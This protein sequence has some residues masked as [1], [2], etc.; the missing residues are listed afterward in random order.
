MSEL[1]LKVLVTGGN[2][3]L[4][5]ELRVLSKSYPYVWFFTDREV[6]DITNS[7]A[8]TSFLEKHQ[9]DVIINAAAYTAVDR[10]ETEVDMATAINHGAVKTLA[11]EAAKRGIKLVNISTDYVFDGEGK[12]PYHTDALC[13]PKSMYGITKRHGEMAMINAAPDH[14][15]II[16]T[17]WLYS[18]YGHNFVKTMLR[19]GGSGKALKVVD[20][21]IG[22]PTNAADLAKV[23]LD[24]LPKLNHEGVRLYHYANKGITSWYGFA[25]AI[26]EL[27]EMN[28]D[29]QPVPSSEYPTPAPRPSYSVMATEDLENDYGVIIPDWKESLRTMLVQLKIGQD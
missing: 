12:E 26:F 14:S 18:V 20:D 3:Q 17:S 6:L 5:S 2:G 22:S 24:I 8:I 28:V 19:V 9:P 1:K 10:A 29:V 15:V 11:E 21:Q 7:N 25:K 4:G 27:E 13:Y 23:I 16:R